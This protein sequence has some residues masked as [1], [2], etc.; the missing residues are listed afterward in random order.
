MKTTF[1]LMLCVFFLAG[2][3]DRGASPDLFDIKLSVKVDQVT[4]CNASPVEVSGYPVFVEVTM[5]TKNDSSGA[6]FYVHL[7]QKES[8][9]G[10]K[11]YYQGSTGFFNKTSNSIPVWLGSDSDIN[12]CYQIYAIVNNTEQF[13]KNT[14]GIKTFNKL[15]G[16]PVSILNLKRIR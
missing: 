14:N 15:P 12:K 1:W 13:E 2:C 16:T 7:I 6:G 4:N 5:K 10:I 11:Y 9:A 3:G 8:G